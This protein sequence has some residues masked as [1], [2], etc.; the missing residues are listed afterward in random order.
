MFDICMTQ[1][2]THA[3]KIIKVNVSIVHNLFAC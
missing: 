3:A 1:L 2:D